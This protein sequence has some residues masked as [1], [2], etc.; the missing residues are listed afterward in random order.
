MRFELGIDAH[1]GVLVD[2]EGR[3]G[4]VVEEHELLRR[5]EDSLEFLDFFDF[6]ENV[7]DVNVAS[8]QRARFVDD[9]VFFRSEE[10]PAAQGEN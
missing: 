8:E 2:G 7:D 6:I 1:V 9:Q 10:F 5:E 4:S 3:L